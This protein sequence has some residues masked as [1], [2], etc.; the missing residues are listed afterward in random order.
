MSLPEVLLWQQLRARPSGLKFRRQHPS[1]PYDL[2]FYCGDARLAV[3]IDGESHERGDRPE[4]DSIRDHWLD[5]HGITTMRIP[6]AEVLRNLEG[7]LLGII[8]ECKARLPLHPAAPRRGP[9]PRDT[10]GEG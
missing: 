6:G 7:V 9:P 10:L 8:E 4:R 2:D 5:Q 3:E 1:G